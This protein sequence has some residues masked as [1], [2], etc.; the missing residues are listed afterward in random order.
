MLRGI[1]GYAKVV[2]VLCTLFE[3]DNLDQDIIIGNAAIERKRNNVVNEGTDDRDFTVGTSSDK[4]V[5]NE[6][7]VKVKSL[8]RCFSER[9]DREMSNI[10][11]T[12]KDKIQ[13]AILTAVDIIVAPKNE[14]AIR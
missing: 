10:V 7:T 3:L 4:L 8:E 2:N 1:G 12:V 14:L 9:I 13:N 5:T 6:N 11:D